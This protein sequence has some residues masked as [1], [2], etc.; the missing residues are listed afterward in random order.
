METLHEKI[1]VIEQEY[2]SKGLLCTSAPGRADFLN[3]HQDYKGLPVVP[4]AINL[5]T[6]MFVLGRDEKFFSVESLN[7]KNEGRVYR[8]RFPVNKPRLRRGRWFGNYFRGI[9]RAFNRKLGIYFPYGL[10]VVVISDVPVASGLASSAALEV[11]FAHLLNVE[12]GL[13]LSVKDIAEVSFTAEHDELKIPCGRLDQYGSA[14][15]GVI[16]LY[17]KPPFNVEKIPF[18][19]LN[20]V[21]LDSGIRHA[22]VE[23]HPKRQQEINEGLKT[24]M[25]NPRIPDH[26]KVKLGYRYDEPRWD[27]LSLEELEPYLKEVNPVSAKRIKFTI[28]MNTLTEVALKIMEGEDPFKLSETLETFGIQLASL[29]GKLDLLGAII[30]KQHELLRDLYDVSLPKLEE[31]RERALKAGALGVKISGAGL[32]GSLIAL[33]PDEGI[34]RRVIKESMKAGASRGF[35]V[36]VDEGVRV[37]PLS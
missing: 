12:Y 8:D 2:G 17:T 14:Y 30:N 21:V 1:K 35:V 4:V 25:E 16:K 31:I 10:K 28:L 23:I 7:L 27:E 37:E 3:T 19:D 22:T 11:A 6:Y 36:K 5:R 33:V 34:G 29:K 9:V 18:K 32:G 26:I 20:L 15:G 24:L 13:V